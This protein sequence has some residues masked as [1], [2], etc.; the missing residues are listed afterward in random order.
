MLDLTSLRLQPGD[1]R[2]E[3]PRVHVEPLEI[4]GQTYTV[5]PAEIEAALDVQAASGGIYLKLAFSARVEGPCFRCLERP[6]STSTCARPSTTPPT[7][8]ARRRL[9]SDYVSGHQ[10]D[11]DGW[12]RDSLVFALPDKILD[13]E[14][15]AGLC[16]HCGEQ[17]EAGV[18]HGC[19][20]AELDSRWAKLRD[21]L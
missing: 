10:L 3:R 7:G 11:L 16:P 9:R 20:E 8:R 2:H 19:V 13:R 14:D 17:L 15:C 5:A 21:L 18:D 4:G 12:V 6:R 1:L